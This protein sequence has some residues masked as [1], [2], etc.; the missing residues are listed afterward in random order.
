MYRR[1]RYQING[2]VIGGVLTAVIALVLQYASHIGFYLS[3]LIS[4]NAIT[5]AMFGIDKGMAKA[6]KV[7]IPEIVLHIFT[8]AGGVIGQLLG[9]SLFHHKT[10]IKKH[11]L[12]LIMPIVSLILYGGLLFWINGR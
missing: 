6:G 11:P 3:W 1:H 10:D 2:I 4:V 9:R 8:L 5:F 12:F 7:R